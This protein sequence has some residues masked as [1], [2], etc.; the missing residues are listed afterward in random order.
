MQEMLNIR[1][2]QNIYERIYNDGWE[3]ISR[4]DYLK[5]VK[6]AFEPSCTHFDD[7]FSDFPTGYLKDHTESLKKENIPK[8]QDQSILPCKSK[9]FCRHVIF[10]DF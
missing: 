7:Q 1:E 2:D 10:C 3:K 5:Y 4:K 6:L 9:V 8:N